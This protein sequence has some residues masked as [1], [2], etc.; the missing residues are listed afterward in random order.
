MID[1]HLHLDGSLSVED[2]KYLCALNGVAEPKDIEST[3][4]V[5]PSCQSLNEYLEKFAFPLKLLQTKESIAYAMKSLIK[6]LYTSGIF[7]AEIRFAPLLHLEGGLSMDEVVETAIHAAEEAVSETVNF[8]V[9]IILCCMRNA[10]LELNKETIQVAESHRNKIC[11][12]DLAGPEVG[13]PCDDFKEVFE[14][15]YNRGLNITIH[16]GEATGSDQVIDAIEEL[17]ATRIGHGV[18]LDLTPENLDL[19]RNENIGFEFCPTSNV[20]TTAIESYSKCPVTAFL[21]NNVLV[22]LDA[23]NLTVSG[24][25]VIDEYR[26]AVKEFNLTQGQV[27]RLLN[28][29]II[30]SF[31]DEPE[32]RWLTSILNERIDQFYAS[33]WEDIKAE[34]EQ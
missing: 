32:K 18:H 17:H 21:Y 1:L 24:V 25:D 14:L 11:G 34:S 23:D 4:K 19:V 20:Q 29:A 30:M 15:A 16:A 13:H 3:L 9:N 2:V 7:Y 28:N 22:C 12:V 8:D 10:S 26:K 31:T 27:Y 6:R 33:L 5:S